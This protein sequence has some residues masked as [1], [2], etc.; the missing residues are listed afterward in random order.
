MPPVDFGRRGLA[1]CGILPAMAFDLPKSIE[2]EFRDGIRVVP[3]YLVPAFRRLETHRL[4][5]DEALAQA[6]RSIETDYLNAQQDKV[7]AAHFRRRS[8][9]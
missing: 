6:N 3:E 1:L 4:T 7:L 9:P 5:Y 2:M 8:G